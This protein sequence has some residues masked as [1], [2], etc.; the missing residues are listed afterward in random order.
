MRPLFS[1]SR[2]PLAII[3]LG[4]CLGSSAWG[5]GSTREKAWADLLAGRLQHGQVVWL[6]TADG[7]KVFA[8]YEPQRKGHGKGA[9]ILLHDMGQHPDWPRVIAPLRNA[10]PRHGW[11]TLSVQMPVLAQGASPGQYAPLLKAVNSRLQ[12][13]VSYLKSQHITPVVLVGY[14]LGA[15]MGAAYL[16]SE[17]DSAVR[18]LIG[19]SMGTVEGTEPSLDIASYLAKLGLPILAI[20]GSRDYEWVLRSVPRLA[21]AGRRAEAANGAEAPVFRQ[22]EIMGADHG[23]TGVTDVLTED[24]VDWLNRLGQNGPE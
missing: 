10:L 9:A 5:A 14:G 6:K 24:V 4:L 21:A 12:A 22:V 18:S 23:Y 11:S 19:I 17:K 7:Q 13:A 1:L 2:A 16:T 8:I 3:A 15:T 20:Y